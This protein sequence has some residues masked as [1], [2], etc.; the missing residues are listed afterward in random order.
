MNQK[1]K[2]NPKLRMNQRLRIYA[3]EFLKEQSPVLIT[4]FISTLL[5]IV[6]YTLDAKHP[7]ELLYPISLS[8][9]CYVVY[10]TMMFYRFVR[11]HRALNEMKLFPDLEMQFSNFTYHQVQKTLY[12]LHNQYRKEAALQ[13]QEQREQKRFL[14]AW[15]H[16]MKTPLS[17]E[18]LLFQRYQEGDIKE[19]YFMK[20]LKKEQ[21]KLENQLEL[22]LSMLRLEE[23]VKDYVPTSIDL[24][25][26]LNEV[27]NQHRSLFIYHKVFPKFE[28]LDKR[29]T[30]LSDRKWND[31]LLLQIINNAV[32][33]SALK[34]GDE[35]CNLYFSVEQEM[36]KV[37]L[38]IKDEGI[39]IPSYDLPR[40]FEPFFTGENGRKTEK[41][42][43][44]GLYFCKEVCQFLGHEISIQ[45]MVGSG[46][47]VKIT[48]LTKL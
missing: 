28:K 8:G 5:I 39:G 42:S 32:K 10:L 37:H 45:S 43:G 36:G 7:V 47:T 41:S 22:V 48:Y 9:S 17:V 14:S 25:E 3:I 16:S 34:E 40:I 21:D 27:I 4:F 23:F 35:P 24:Q 33:Y 19:E 2:M 26:E 31:M 12:E 18:A 13:L 20:G 29:V 15:I 38:F 11:F 46:T 1:L 6:F 44:I 30:I